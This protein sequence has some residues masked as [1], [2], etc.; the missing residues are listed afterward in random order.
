MDLLGSVDSTVFFDFALCC[1]ARA[2]SLF[3]VLVYTTQLAAWLV[4]N[5]PF[6]VNFKIKLCHFNQ[7][8]IVVSFALLFIIIDYIK[9]KESVLGFSVP[10]Q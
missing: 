7:L 2:T 9:E 6:S 10:E 8:S 1:F 5:F 4:E 3:F